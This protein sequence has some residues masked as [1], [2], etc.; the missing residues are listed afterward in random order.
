MLKVAQAP[1][2]RG[3]HADVGLAS[4]PGGDT[5]DRRGRG[6]LLMRCIMTLAETPRDDVT[7][8]A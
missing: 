3:F 5:G 8:M 6:D 4:T 7:E 2:S 1:R